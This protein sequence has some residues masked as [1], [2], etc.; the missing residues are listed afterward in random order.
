MRSLRCWASWRSTLRSCRSIAQRTANQACCCVTR[1][2]TRYD[3]RLHRR[4]AFAASKSYGR[5]GADPLPAKS[6]R[7]PGLTITT[8]TGSRTVI[9]PRARLKAN[10]FIAH[11]ISRYVWRLSIT[12]TVS[13]AVTD[14]V[15][16]PHFILIGL[17]I[18]GPLCAL[19]TAERAGSRSRSTG[20]PLGPGAGVPRWDLGHHHPA[21]P[22]RRRV[23]GRNRVHVGRRDHGV[24]N[25]AVGRRSPRNGQTALG[26]RPSTHALLMG[27]W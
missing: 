10:P 21:H 4:D 27:N 14:A 20:G 3:F 12:L 15:L 6:V 18:V 2:C 16:G 7:C 19:F 25:Q 11:R 9:V 22:H 1:T 5:N 26:R 8:T 13:I 17:L 23:D 24:R